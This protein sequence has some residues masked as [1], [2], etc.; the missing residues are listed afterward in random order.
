MDDAV[1][2]KLAAATT[3]ENGTSL[4]FKTV[5][6]VNINFLLDDLALGILGLTLGSAITVAQTRSGNP[7]V[8]KTGEVTSE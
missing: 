2:V 7:I 3:N 6:G 8:F 1:R 5:E 4:M